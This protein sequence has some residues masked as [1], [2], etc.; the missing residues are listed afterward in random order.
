M[1]DIKRPTVDKEISLGSNATR[2][3][4]RTPLPKLQITILL[5]L[6]LCEP[7]TSTS[8]YPYI[9]QL[10]TELNITKGGQ[11]KAGYYAGLIESLYFAAEALTV[12]QWGR[13]SDHV[14]RKP[15]LLAG[16]AG[17]ALSMICFGLSRTFTT[18]VISRCLCGVLNGNTG[19]MKS[20]MGELLDTTNR[21]EGLSLLPV[22]WFAGATIGPMIGGSLSRPYEQFP[23]YFKRAF[24]RE[25]PYFFPNL[26][27]AIFVFISFLLTLSL[28]EETLPRCRE[29]SYSPLSS[30]T[31][32]SIEESRPPLRQ[33]FTYPVT[34]S[35]SNY[36]IIAFLRS[37]FTVLLPLLMAMPVEI[38]GLGCSTIAIG[39]ILGI[40][41][42][43]T[44]LFQT[45]FFAK[46]VRK[47]GERRVFIAGILSSCLSSV[48]FLLISII[49]RRTGVTWVVWSLL[50][51]S[52]SLFPITGM[53]YSC[54]FIYII[55]SSPNKNSL[56][57]IN[58]ISQ[59]TVSLS[60]A[61]GPALA[62]SLFSFSVENNILGGGAVYIILFMLSCLALL[63][64]LRLPPRPW[65]VDE[66]E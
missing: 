65:D 63:P 64:A 28:F 19:I 29:L 13:I 22:V 46:F 2:E 36:A 8:I 42:A 4:R 59:T 54:V 5:I 34:L 23:T 17:S 51:F 33:L 9:N 16:L 62:T 41:G 32:T 49:V 50:T 12:L 38:G 60:R 26:G 14:G 15:V 56:G 18:L 57:A 3:R 1:S 31:D 43:Y 52:I 7:I 25:Y 11:G 10:I 37:M 48:L 30:A 53:C 40:L 24:W 61:I 58:G 44:G 21:A 27:V 39:Y 47:F 20:V 55:A 6:Q 35:V 45:L 66:S